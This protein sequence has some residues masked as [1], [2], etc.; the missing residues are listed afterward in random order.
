[1]DATSPNKSEFRRWFNPDEV[2][3]YWMNR[4]GAK[5]GQLLAPTLDRDQAHFLVLE[6]RQI[7]QMMAD[8]DAAQYDIER[9]SLAVQQREKELSD[10]EAAEQRKIAEYRQR[11]SSRPMG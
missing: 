7:Y 5:L 3:T 4:A 11:R 10:A 9:F 1:M 8:F 6:L 2:Q